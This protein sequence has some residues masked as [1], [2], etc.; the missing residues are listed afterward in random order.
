MRKFNLIDW[1]FSTLLVGNV[2]HL[3]NPSDDLTLAIASAVGGALISVGGSLLGGLFGRRKGYTDPFARWSGLASEA[4]YNRGRQLM[5]NPYGLGDSKVAM[6]NVARDTFSAGHQMLGLQRDQNFARSGLDQAGGSKA[7]MD[8]YAG[9]QFSEGLNTAY[10]R[11]EEMDFRAR[12]E[13]MARGE[14]MLMALSSKNPI[15]SQLAAQNYWNTIDDQN[16]FNQ[17]I[18]QSLGGW[19]ENWLSGRNSSNG[20]STGSGTGT[21]NEYDDFLTNNTSP[22]VDPYA[23]STDPSAGG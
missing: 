17:S 7:R 5:D 21:I 6:R 12:E 1:A 16:Q 19:Y 13:Q 14:N 3:F 18:G 4:Q 23:Y 10:N 20:P 11:I 15:Y 9:Q 2:L 22:P 8:Y